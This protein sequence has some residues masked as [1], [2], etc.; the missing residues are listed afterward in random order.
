MPL[1]SRDKDV[2]AFTEENHRADRL[3]DQVTRN[4]RF[5]ADVPEEGIGEGFSVYSSD[6]R[7]L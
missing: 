4:R 3:V 6:P 7:F 1:G 2:H 5:S